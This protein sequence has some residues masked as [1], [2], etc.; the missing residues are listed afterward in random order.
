MSQSGGH[1]LFPTGYM[2]FRPKHMLSPVGHM[3]WIVGCMMLAT[4]YQL[5]TLKYRQVNG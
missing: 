1:I 4:T 3:E 2:F 5:I